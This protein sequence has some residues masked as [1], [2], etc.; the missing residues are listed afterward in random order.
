MS[1]TDL[2][3]SDEG[4]DVEGSDDENSTSVRETVG[5]QNA[6]SSSDEQSVEEGDVGE[7][8]EEEDREEER[9]KE[10]DE[11]EQEER[12]EE[13]EEMEGEKSEQEDEH[14]EKVEIKND[15]ENEG[16]SEEEEAEQSDKEEKQSNKEDEEEKPIASSK[17]VSSMDLFGEDVSSEEDEDEVEKGQ[18]TT[19]TQ[20]KETAAESFQHHDLGSDEEQEEEQPEETQINVEIPYCKFSLGSEMAFVKL[21]NFLSVE[22]KPFD[23]TTYEDEFEE[24]EVMDDEGRSRLKLRVENTIRWRNAKD[25]EGN[26]IKES[27]ARVVRWSD[28][29]MSLLLGAEVFDIHKTKIDGEHNHLFVQQGT[30][31]QAQAIFR[32]KLTFR[33]HS[34]NSQ[35]HR[36]MTLSIADRVSKTGKIKILPVVGKDPESQKSEL[37]K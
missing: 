24:D 8:G 28:G 34:T 37:I 10:D 5:K 16:S 31:L 26:D 7:E 22:T 30:G 11:E 36:K 18:E 20:E 27:N 4:S 14:E 3:G 25:D 35:T 21:P 6:Q 29:T 32:E 15:S 2:F 1:M 13:E 33:P 23:L 12:Q 9:N 17:N 19:T